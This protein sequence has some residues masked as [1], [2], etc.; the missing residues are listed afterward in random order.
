M[1]GAKIWSL[2]PCGGQLRIYSFIAF[3]L[4]NRWD[5]YTPLLPSEN[6]NSFVNKARQR[7]GDKRLLF[8]V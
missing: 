1:A 6:V 5:A 8:Y 2:D 3:H 4:L 7:T